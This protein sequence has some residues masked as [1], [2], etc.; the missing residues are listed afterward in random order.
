MYKYIRTYLC[1]EYIIYE[2]RAL[3]LFC[4]TLGKTSSLLETKQNEVIDS[5]GKLL[6]WPEQYFHF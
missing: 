2:L 1:T 6:L 4:F 5:R 3:F